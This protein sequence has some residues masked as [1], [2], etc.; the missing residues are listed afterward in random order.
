MM[1][2]TTSRKEMQDSLERTRRMITYCYAIENGFR[3]DKTVDSIS[4]L[5]PELGV[6]FYA[7]KSFYNLRPQF[8]KIYLSMCESTEKMIETLLDLDIFEDSDDDKSELIS[9]ID[10]NPNIDTFKVV[11][12]F[13]DITGQNAKMFEILALNLRCVCKPERWYSREYA[14]NT[15]K[16]IDE[17][18]YNM[19]NVLI[20]RGYDEVIDVLIE[21]FGK[22]ANGF[23]EIFDNFSPKREMFRPKR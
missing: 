11:G 5:D 19:V 3:A 14:L 23:K 17:D 18:L 6:A 9:N 16:M 10:E 21:H 22:L 13:I 4:K 12:H 1:Y 2:N 7:A 8:A 15:I 20:D